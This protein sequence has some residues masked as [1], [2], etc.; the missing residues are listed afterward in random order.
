MINRCS[1]WKGSS[2]ASLSNYWIVTDISNDSCVLD[3]SW[4]FPLVCRPPVCGIFPNMMT[5]FMAT[6][7][8]SWERRG[9]ETEVRKFEVSSCST[10]AWNLFQHYGVWY[11]QCV[12]SSL[13]RWLDS[14]RRSISVERE[15]EKGLMCGSLRWSTVLQDFKPAVTSD[16]GFHIQ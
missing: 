14:W 9:K 16:F 12:E 11:S 13:T 5:W 15:R 8:L 4:M 2:K 3:F 6:I 10:S 1:D 7:Y